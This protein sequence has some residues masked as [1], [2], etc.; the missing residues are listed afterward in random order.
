MLRLKMLEKSETGRDLLVD[1]MGTL[2]RYNTLHEVELDEEEEA[3]LSWPLN[4]LGQPAEEC[5]T[6]PDCKVKDF[7]RRTSTLRLQL[8]LDIAQT[9]EF[10]EIGVHLAHFQVDDLP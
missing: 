9:F 1:Q 2:P 6:S 5:V 7:A 10:L 8:G 4:G 3:N